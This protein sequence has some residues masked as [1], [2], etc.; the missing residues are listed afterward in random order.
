MSRWKYQT[1]LVTVGEN[2]AS[3]RSLTAGERLKF[4]EM[5]KTMTGVEVKHAIVKFCC[6][7]PAPGS[8]EFGDMPGD[9]FDAVFDK[10]IEMAGGGA[11]KKDEPAP[12]G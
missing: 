9:L 12:A 5:R 8:E 7:D 4:T 1:E 3:I 6:V 11:E 2:S 10:I